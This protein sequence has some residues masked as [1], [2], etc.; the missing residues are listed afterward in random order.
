MSD[1]QEEIVRNPVKDRIDT[2]N[3]VAEM[4]S[5]IQTQAAEIERLE[6]QLEEAKS[7]VERI[8]PYIKDLEKYCSYYEDII[9][10]YCEECHVPH[11]CHLS[12]SKCP[13]DRSRPTVTRGELVEALSESLDLFFENDAL[14]P[15]EFGSKARD[16]IARVKGER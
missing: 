9:K 3:T 16:L 14:V 11:D 13:L 10:T 1:T 7:T 8:D 15:D 2:V 12:C 6:K 4:S 5:T